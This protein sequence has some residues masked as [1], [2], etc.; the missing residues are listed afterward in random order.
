M[1]SKT[2]SSSSRPAIHSLEF[3]TLPSSSTTAQL[4]HVGTLQ[5]PDLL[6]A[7]LETE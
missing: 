5:N 1:L 6:L 4:S 3:S 7:A 2:V